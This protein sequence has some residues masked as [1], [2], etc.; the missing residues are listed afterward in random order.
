MVNTEK[1][2]GELVVN[3]VGIMIILASFKEKNANH[4]QGSNT[5]NNQNW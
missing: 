1:E 4:S 3:G 2:A 5:K